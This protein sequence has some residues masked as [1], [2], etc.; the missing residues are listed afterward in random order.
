MKNFRQ[1]ITALVI[2]SILGSCSKKTHPAE[3]TSTSTTNTSAAKPAS[4]APV[5][6]VKTVV[7]KVIIVN[8]SVAS[9]TFDGRYYYDLG[10]HRYWRS[11]KDGK[12]YIYN[13]SMNSDP[14][15]KKQ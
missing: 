3:S 13:K 1:L 15:F 4:P 2:I 8:D 10:G 6:K 11:N 14:A 12:Y 7:P 5:K 9:K